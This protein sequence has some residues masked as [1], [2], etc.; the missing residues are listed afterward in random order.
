MADPSAVFPQMKQFLEF[1]DGDIANLVRLAPVFAKHG[2][3]ITDQFY[4]ILGQYPETARLLD[5]RVDALKATHKRYLGELFAGDYGETYF[6]NRLRVGQVHVRVG[7][8][9]FFVEAVMSFLRTA[10]LLAIRQEVADPVEAQAL[11]VSYIKLL[12]LDLLIVNLAY[13]E[14]RLTRLTKFT[15]MSRRLLENCISRGA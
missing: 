11:T 12:D 15:G 14:E 2:A 4:T 9:A 6:Q 5:G 1:G 13:G 8:D 7:L 10:G 3:A